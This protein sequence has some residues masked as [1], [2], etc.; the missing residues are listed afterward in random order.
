MWVTSAVYE[1][2]WTET[3]VE[4]YTETDSKGNVST[5]TRFV[6][7]Y[8]P[9]T[10]TAYDNNGCG[11]SISPSK[12]DW[13]CSHF[14]NRK[15]E[16]RFHFGQSSW[17]DGNAYST[18]FAGGDEKMVVMTT[19]HSYT[20]KVAATNS[21]RPYPK[22]T[23]KTGLYDYPLADGF[24]TWSI[25]GDDRY[26]EAN[27]R[28]CRWNAK[29][30]REKQV[31]IWLLIYRDEPIQRALDQESYWQGGN[32]NELVL[33]V[34]L[35]ASDKLEWAHAFSWTEVESLVSQVKA[36]AMDQKVFKPNELVEKVV[37]SVQ[38]Q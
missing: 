18:A 2:G 9:P 28:L 15:F 21:I 10:W 13:F 1:E 14:G 4:T 17:G 32:K 33:C 36:D 6:T 7:E 35:D 23:D 5:K 27:G 8:H 25:L 20:N 37:A 3:R 24:E 29:L 31:R 19:S 12:F 11:L 30:G 22:I 34:G 38:K 26:T 16:S